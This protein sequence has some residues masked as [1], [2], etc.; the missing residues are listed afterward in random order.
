MNK[1]QSRKEKKTRKHLELV[2]LQTLFSVE[3]V[4]REARILT[5]GAG[6]HASA[7]R[8]A[9]KKGQQTQLTSRVARM[10]TPSSK[11]CK[12]YEVESLRWREAQK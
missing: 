7:L 5:S 10:E 1:I 6:F 11:L 9:G 12:I 8:T 4:A 3:N 2:I